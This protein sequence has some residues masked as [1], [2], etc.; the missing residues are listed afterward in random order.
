MQLNKIQIHKIKR[1]NMQLQINK[2][3]R[4]EIC[5]YKYIKNKGLNMQLQKHKDYWTDYAVANI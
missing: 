3:H 4:T 5:I 1:I 2:D